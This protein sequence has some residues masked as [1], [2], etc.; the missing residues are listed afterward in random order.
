MLRGLKKTGAP[1]W[2]AAIQWADRWHVPPWEIWNHPG[3]TRWMNRAQAYHEELD[4]AT[5]KRPFRSLD[6]P[7]VNDFAHVSAGIPYHQMSED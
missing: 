1:T 2:A 5:H 6:G 3:A 7:A 4:D